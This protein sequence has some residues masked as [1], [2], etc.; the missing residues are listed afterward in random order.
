MDERE[1]KWLKGIFIVGMIVVV[2]RGVMSMM[3]GDFGE[4]LKVVFFG[5]LI[6]FGVCGV[7][8]LIMMLVAHWA[9]EAE[10]VR[11]FGVLKGIAFLVG[12]TVLMQQV[13]YH[14]GFKVLVWATDLLETLM[15]KWQMPVVDVSDAQFGCGI[16]GIVAALLFGLIF[17]VAVMSM[18]EWIPVLLFQLAGTFVFCFYPHI[19][20]LIVMI[21]FLALIFKVFGAIGRSMD[22]A[23]D[24]HPAAGY[25]NRSFQRAVREGTSIFEIL[26]H[27]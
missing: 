2:L 26:K 15:D 16:A 19:V 22:D 8:A 10:V 9:A 7:A 27:F 18:R 3:M 4:M 23:F 11:F 6:V 20:V 21:L 17:F 24:R 1:A 14:V 12:S 13:G 25:S 5:V